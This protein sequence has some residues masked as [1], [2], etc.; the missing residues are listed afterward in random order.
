[1]KGVNMYNQVQS[2][3]FESK[4]QRQISRELGINRR[5]VKK[6]SQ[7]DI[8]EACEYF[9]QGVKRS[10]GFN[11]A[12]KHFY[13]VLIEFLGSWHVTEHLDGK[14]GC[15]SDLGFPGIV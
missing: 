6:L 3:L 10:S 12:H 13:G 15:I 2:L 9:K 4:S 5:T 11:D 8:D 7:L 14:P 1:V